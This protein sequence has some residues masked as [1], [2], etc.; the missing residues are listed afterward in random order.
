MIIDT[1]AS[2]FAIGC[3]LSQV[4]D[5]QE[6]MISYAGRTLNPSERNYC[7]TRKELLATVYFVRYFKQ[8][9]LGRPFTVRT[10]HSALTWLRRTRELIGQNA[11]WFTILEEYQ[12]SVLHRSGWKHNSADS[13]SR[14]PR[15]NKPICMACH[16]EQWGRVR[17]FVV[18]RLELPTRHH[19]NSEQVHWNDPKKETTPLLILTVD[20]KSAD[21]TK[22]N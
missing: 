20:D 19:R 22:L 10:E 16:P 5:G 3:V 6:R 9:L 1:D 21:V 4:Q 11:R 14:H 7:M 12:Y 8:Y 13:I 15:L 2:D 17:P 18:K